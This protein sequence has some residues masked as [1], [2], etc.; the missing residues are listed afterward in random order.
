MP[1]LPD[2]TEALERTKGEAV[3]RI[4]SLD[5]SKWHVEGNTVYRYGHLMVFQATNVEKQLWA[6][7]KALESQQGRTIIPARG[8]P[9]ENR[10]SRTQPR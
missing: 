6:D 2:L 5:L 9:R 10:Y 1:T 7:I 3:D 4:N 8:P